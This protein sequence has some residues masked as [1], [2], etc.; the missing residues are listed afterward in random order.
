MNCVECD[1]PRDFFF[2]TPVNDCG[3][4]GKDCTS[5]EDHHEYVSPAPHAECRIAT[6]D[7]IEKRISAAHADPLV[8]GKGWRIIVQ[9]VIEDMRNV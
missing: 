8:V 7:E 9:E 3:F 5:P 1:E 2:H 4:N 6:L